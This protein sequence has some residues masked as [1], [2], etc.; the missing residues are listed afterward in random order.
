MKSSLLSRFPAVAP[1]FEDSPREVIATAGEKAVLECAA[2]GNPKP[3][4][5]WMRDNQLIAIDTV[6][7]MQWQNGTLVID[8]VRET[9]AGNYTCEANNGMEVAPRRS[10]LL[11][12][13]GEYEGWWEPH[14]DCG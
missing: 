12:V 13:L 14:S 2:S 9:D 3:Q 4:I 10:V 8:D 7:V 11:S 1:V 6:H 5:R